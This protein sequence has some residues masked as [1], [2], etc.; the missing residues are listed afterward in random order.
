MAVGRQ[1]ESSSKEPSEATI[2]LNSHFGGFSD[3]VRRCNTNRRTGV[4]YKIEQ[5]QSYPV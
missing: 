2:V 1:V 4:H 3:L 5:S